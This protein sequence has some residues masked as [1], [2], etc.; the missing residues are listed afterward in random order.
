MPQNAVMRGVFIGFMVLALSSFILA[1]LIGDSL[2]IPITSFLYLLGS[3]WMLITIY[4][5]I[6]FVFQDLVLLA[7]KFLHF[8]SAKFTIHSSRGSWTEMLFI[9]GFILLLVVGGHLRYLSKERV[10]LPIQLGKT[11]GDSISEQSIRIVAVS[12]LHLGYTIGKKEL[13]KWVELINKEKPDIVLI[14]GDL[15]DNSYRPLKDRNFA[16]TLRN[17][18]APM[19]VYA[20]MGNHEYISSRDN[21]E[22]EQFFKESNIKLLRDTAVEVDSLFYVVGRDDRSNPNRRELASLLNGLDHSKPIILLDHQPYNLEDAE[23]N[24]VDLQLSGH[25]HQ[26]QV[27]PI[28]LITG[29]M[30]EVDHGYKQ[31]GD[32]HCYVSSGLGIWGGKFRIGTVS[33][34]VVIDINK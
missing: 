19:G 4:F 34:Y 22:H 12:D 1:S 18:K 14:A 25:T 20:C 24:K 21:A 11:M 7:N 27:W 9:L 32:T 13:G 33:E 17:I 10:Y 2:P 30:Y 5:I 26:G 31:K 15:V 23:V 8:T 3:S 16:E 29:W 28:S 6:A